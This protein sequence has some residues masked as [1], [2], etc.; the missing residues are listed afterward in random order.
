MGRNP[1]DKKR[2]NNEKSKEKIAIK[3]LVYFQKNGLTGF[4][5]SKIAQ[6]LSMSK[7]T[8]YNH[9]KTKDD[10]VSAALDYKLYTIED[11]QTVL[12]NLTLDYSER[13]RKAMIYFCVQLFEVST[14]LISEVK[15]NYPSLWR[16]V[17]HFQ[18]TVFINLKS[19]YEVGVEI[20]VFRGEINP[21]LLA[22]ND[23]SF[24]EMLGE[25]KYFRE[26]GIEVLVA[27]NHHFKTKFNGI[28]EPKYQ[29]KKEG[30]I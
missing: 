6:D 11:Y 3:A 19:Y 9:Y 12:E 4:T 20:G 27:V 21:V 29:L 22:L 7:T 14:N 15:A 5:M 18:S 1:V 25:N 8:I 23:L 16:K 13:Y 17:E 30:L 10:L 26:S 2:Y 28:I 24:F